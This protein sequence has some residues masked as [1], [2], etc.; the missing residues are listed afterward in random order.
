MLNFIT[1]LQRKFLNT[2]DSATSLGWWKYETEIKNEK[3]I[4]FF[5]LSTIPKAISK[6][7]FRNIICLLDHL[8]EK[9]YYKPHHV[10]IDMNRFGKTNRLGNKI[11][12]LSPNALILYSSFQILVD[13]YEDYETL[14]EDLKRHPSISVANNWI[15]IEEL[16]KWWTID[17]VD[18]EKNV[19]MP[20]RKDYGLS[21]SFWGIDD[22]G[23]EDRDKPQYLE[24]TKERER[25]QELNEEF[26]I[27][28]NEMLIR[29]TVALAKW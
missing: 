8:K 26:N 5:M 29:C 19:T 12:N 24:Y 28:S 14:I 4:L 11:Y 2:P 3:P 25:I 13:V 20:Q 7:W 22:N 16:Y 27:K 21:E 18:H 23:V 1:K 9:Y 17:R 6:F 15:E 10:K